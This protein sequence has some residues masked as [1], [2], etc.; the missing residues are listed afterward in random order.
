MERGRSAQVYSD[1]VPPLLTS[2]DL[3]RVV[4]ATTK[5]VEIS[6]YHQSSGLAREAI[7]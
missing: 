5:Y 6:A 2:A 7:K 3:K 1:F 4:S